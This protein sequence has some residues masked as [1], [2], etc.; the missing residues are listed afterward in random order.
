MK[1]SLLALSCLALTACGGG[2]GGDSAP[3]SGTSTASTGNSLINPLTMSLTNVALPAR[4]TKVT[5]SLNQSDALNLVDGN[6]STEKSWTGS[7]NGDY[8]QLDLGQLTAVTEIE[9]FSNSTGFDSSDRQKK[10][11]ISE[12]GKTWKE[13]ALPTG[14]GAA[15]SQYFGGAK[16]DSETCYYSNPARNIRYVKVTL[17]K[18]NSKV[19]LYEIEVTGWRD[20]R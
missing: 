7:A 18:D 2:G 8:V 16:R 17:L 6:D 9:L 14:A 19:T 3:S 4:G 5:A 11:E 1:K 10:I 15:C 12:D 20:I 13:T